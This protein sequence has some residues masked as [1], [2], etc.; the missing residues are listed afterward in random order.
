MQTMAERRKAMREQMQQRTEE[1]FE[2]K[3]KGGGMYGNILRKDVTVKEWVCRSNEKEPHNLDIIPYTVGANPSDPKARKGDFAYV[4]AYYVHKKVGVNE[5]SVVCLSKT[6][7]LPCPICEDRKK[8]SD[9]YGFEHEEVGKLKASRQCVYNVWVYDNAEEEKKGVQVWIVAHWFFEKELMDI[10]KKRGG[11]YVAFADPDEG[12]QIQFYRKGKEHVTFSGFQFIDRNYRIEDEVLE[13]TY[14][15]ED[16]VH[17]PTYEEVSAMHYGRKRETAEPHS[18]GHKVDNKQPEPVGSIMKC[19]HGHTIGIDLHQ[20]DQCNNC[21][22]KFYNVCVTMSEANK[23]GNI[24]T[25]PLIEEK[26]EEPAA[27]LRRR[28]NS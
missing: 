4:A 11:G 26:K 8:L 20:M 16:I 6:F 22:E 2:R 3:D 25:T 24:P 18:S 13:S 27:P 9:E 5:D 28:F 17:I 1:S 23:V 15:I 7:G 10:A 19:P 14:C 12:K 21:E